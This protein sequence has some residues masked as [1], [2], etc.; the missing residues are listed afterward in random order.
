MLAS[1]CTGRRKGKEK[2]E[3]GRKGFIVKG[4]GKGILKGWGWWKE[5]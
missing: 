4:E 1:F 2:M 3:K 5:R